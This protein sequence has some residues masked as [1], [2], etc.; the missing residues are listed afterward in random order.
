VS[1]TVVGSV[2]LDTVETPFGRNEEGLGGA[3]TF[4]ALVAANYTRTHLVGVIGEDFPEEHVQLLGSKDID[5]DGLERAEGKTFRWSGKYHEDINERDT[6]H[7]HLNVFEHFHP[8][9]PDA[10]K[11][12]QYLFLAN[13]HPALQLE[14]LENSSAKFVGMDTMNLWIDIALDDLKAVLRKVDVLVINDAEAK[15]LTDTKNVIQA[16]HDIKGLGPKYVVVKKGEHGCLLFSPNG[17]FSAPAYPLSEVI[18][19]TGAGDSFAGGFMGHIAEQDSTDPETLRQ[20]VI[21]GSVTAS[22]CCERFGPE[23]TAEITRADID[24]R[25]GDFRALTTF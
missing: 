13:I 21:H 22:F 17:V 8:K 7:T 3:A 1:I 9:L 15:Q 24:A 18:D 23:R 19:P 5:L 6:L 2:A 11:S 20:A 16:A 4:F 14:V 10:A 25:Y 12:A